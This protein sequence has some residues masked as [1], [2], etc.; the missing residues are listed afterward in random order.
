MKVPLTHPV[1]LVWGKVHILE[2]EYCVW[3]DYILNLRTEMLFQEVLAT[4]LL[5]QP[6]I[7]VKGSHYM[8]HLK[9]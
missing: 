7:K 9:V 2:S 5:V 8:A 3:T 6:M 1:G 4:I